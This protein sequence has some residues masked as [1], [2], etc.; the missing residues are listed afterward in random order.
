MGKMGCYSLL[1]EGWDVQ[2]E[3][4]RMKRPGKAAHVEGLLVRRWES[5]GCVQIIEG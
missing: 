4:G 1:G 5:E 2:M 3:R